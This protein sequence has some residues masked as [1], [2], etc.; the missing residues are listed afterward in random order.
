MLCYSMLHN[1]MLYVDPPVQILG[2]RFVP[3]KSTPC[4]Q[5]SGGSGRIAGLG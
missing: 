1:M 4:R 2:I 3:G 5:E